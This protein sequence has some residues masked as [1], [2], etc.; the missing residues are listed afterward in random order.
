MVLKEFYDYK[1][2]VNSD[3]KWLDW[4]KQKLD[5]YDPANNI[6]DSLLDEV[7]KDT[8]ELKKRNYWD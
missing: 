4:A 2:T 5:W 3:E 8:L 6:D 1:K 7:N